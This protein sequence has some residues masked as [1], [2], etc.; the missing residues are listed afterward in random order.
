MLMKSTWYFLFFPLMWNVVFGLIAIF[1][2]FRTMS[3]SARR[4]FRTSIVKG[5]PYTGALYLSE[6]NGIAPTWSRC[7]CETNCALILCLIFA[8]APSSGIAWIDFNLFSVMTLSRSCIETIAGRKNP[9]SNIN[10]SSSS[11]T[12]TIFFPTS[13][14]PPTVCIFTILV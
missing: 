4:E 3:L 5:V 14:N 1:L 9:S 8:I 2:F 11:S 13:E 10:A 12:T 6:R 7:A